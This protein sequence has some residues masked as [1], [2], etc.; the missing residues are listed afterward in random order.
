MR[1]YKHDRFRSRIFLP[2]DIDPSGGGGNPGA[3]QGGAAG[4]GGATTTNLFEGLDLNDLDP[5]T[6]K[7]VEAANAKF[8]TL[9]KEKEE[10][11]KKQ[12]FSDEQA[13]KFQSAFDQTQAQLQRLTGGGTSGQSPEEQAKE[14]QIVNYT[15]IIQQKAPGLDPKV[16]RVQGEMMYDMLGQHAQQI[17]ADIGRDFAPFAQNL[18]GREAEHAFQEAAA[19]DATGALQDKDIAETVWAQVTELVKQGQQVTT[20]VVQNLIGME[21]YKAAQTGKFQF[22]NGQQQQQQQQQSSMPQIS[23]LPNIGRLSGGG[24]FPQRQQQRDPNAPRTGPLNADGQK[25]LDAVLGNWGKA[26]EKAPDYRKK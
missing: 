20:G 5:E 13:R 12:K 22:G 1:Y 14:Q 11:E 17:K 6:K 24:N 25:A 8:A 9:Q 21:A 18:L 19:G 4:G 16:A 2:P 15:A 7:Q 10:L 3:Q 23:Q 26:A